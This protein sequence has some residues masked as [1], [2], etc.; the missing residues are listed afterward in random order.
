MFDFNK[1]K[2]SVSILLI[3]LALIFFISK[4]KIKV[5]IPTAFDD[6][7]DKNP[8]EFIEMDVVKLFGCSINYNNTLFVLVLIIIA[9]ILLFVFSDDNQISEKVKSFKEKI[10]KWDIK[11]FAISILVL[12]IILIIGKSCS[13]NSKSANSDA[14]QDTLAAP[15]EFAVDC[16][17]VAP[18]DEVNPV[19]NSYKDI[20]YDTIS[21]TK[22]STGISR[23]SEIKQQQANMDEGVASGFSTGEGLSFEELRRARGE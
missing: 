13:N 1:K 6:T 2:I 17:A 14:V 11:L 19:E 22:N 3:T 23:F 10:K 12:I 15:E 5:E 9:A 16:V 4:V 7:I 20:N 8:T 18:V 21:N